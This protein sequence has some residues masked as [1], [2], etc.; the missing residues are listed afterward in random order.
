MKGLWATLRSKQHTDGIPVLKDISFEIQKGESL[1]IVGRNGAG[2]STLLKIISGVMKASSGE[3][4]VNGSIGAL[5]ELGSGFDLEYSGIENLKM[6]ATLAGISENLDRK[7]QRMADFADIGEFI[8][9]PVKTYSSGMIVRL[10]FAVITETKPDLLITDEI[11]AV[12]DEAFQ[13][14]CL[15]WVEKYLAGGGTLLLVSHSIY[16]IQTICKNAMW[17]ENGSIKMYGDSHKV[18]KAYQTAILGQLDASNK[19]QDLNTYHV[20]DASILVEGKGRGNQ[21]NMMETFEVVATVYTPDGLKPGLSIGIV[22]FDGHAIYGTY[23]SE[24]GCIPVFIDD[25]HV[26]FR[27]KFINNKLLPGDYKIKLHSMTPDQL[28]M[29]DTLELDLHIEG[30][31]REL[32]VCRLETEWS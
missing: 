16:H 32:G 13:V 14:K 26:Q 24:V 2:K 5:L 18:A 3:V 17:L 8:N 15:A 22:G 21:I 12:G 11:L 19:H 10:G 7:I 29:V 20:S 30:K 9:E 25:L 28:Q 31:T 27:I 1:A 23:S 4:N 6:A